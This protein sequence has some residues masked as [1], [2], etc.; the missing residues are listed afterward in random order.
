MLI[1]PIDFMLEK[2]SRVKVAIGK[3]KKLNV[4]TLFDLAII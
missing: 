2:T 4:I 3:S 1:L